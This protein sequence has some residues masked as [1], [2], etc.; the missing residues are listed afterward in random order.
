MSTLLERLTAIANKP[1]RTVLGILSGTS[2]DAIDVAVCRIGGGGIPRPGHPGARV[3]LVFYEEFP[4][5]PMLP[6]RLRAVDQLT[7][8]DVAELHVEIGE[9]FGIACLA[10]IR[11]AGLDPRAVDLVGSHGQTIY[12]HGSV[13]GATRATLQLG[14]PDV[15]AEQ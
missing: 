6:V 10:A 3:E 13:P 7:P 2:A 15:I 5:D 4:H 1:V 8:R 9:A 11:S 12:H 14:D